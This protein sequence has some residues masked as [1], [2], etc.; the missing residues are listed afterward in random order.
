MN[1]IS[2]LFAAGLEGLRKSRGWFLVFGI[3]LSS[4]EVLAA[5]VGRGEKR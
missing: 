2:S 4:A 5:E 3:A 1:N